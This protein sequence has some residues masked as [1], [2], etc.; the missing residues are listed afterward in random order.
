[1]SVEAPQKQN[2]MECELGDESCWMYLIISEPSGEYEESVD[3]LT[4][5]VLQDME[6]ATCV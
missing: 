5:C 6:V 3:K 1:M 2:E 4:A